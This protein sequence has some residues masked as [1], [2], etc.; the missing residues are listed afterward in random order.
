V[1]ITS[2]DD[3]TP[4]TD[5][6]AHYEALLAQHGAVASGVGWNSDF[7]QNERFAQLSE[8]LPREDM[9]VSILD[10][11]CGFGSLV[12]FVAA[13]REHFSYIGYDASPAMIA[14]ARERQQRH[15]HAIFESEWERVPPCDYAVAS[16]LFNVRDG[17][18]DESWW[19]Y[20]QET[21]RTIHG[22][23]KLGWAANFLTSYS[24][25]ELMRPELYYADPLALF[26]WCKRELSPFVAL[27]HDYPLF[28][29]TILVRKASR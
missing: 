18:S 2:D 10:F 21:L 25:R 11:G 4:A 27:H 3:S 12:E 20:I 24:D 19:S 1:A 13:R 5:A 29:F 17:W 8:I 15:P 6:V 9:P 28:D 14:H 22:R 23:S 7:A 16:G 26:D